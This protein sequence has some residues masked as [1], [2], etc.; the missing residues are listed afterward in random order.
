VGATAFI[1]SRGPGTEHLGGDQRHEPWASQQV[2][3]PQ[4]ARLL[5]HS[6]QPLKT[7]ALD[8]QRRP[9]NLPAD[10]TKADAH[11]D[12]YRHLTTVLL[13]G[14]PQFLF[15][16]SQSDEQDVGSGL[17]DSANGLLV[18]LR[19]LFKAH[20][21]A[22]RANDPKVREALGQDRAS[23]F[24][25]AGSATEEED[26]VPCRSSMLAEPDEQIRAGDS[27][28]EAG[29]AED[30]V[31][32][33]RSPHQRQPIGQDKV[34]GSHDLGKSRIPRHAHEMIDVGCDHHG[35]CT[36]QDEPVHRCDR[37]GHGHIVDPSIAD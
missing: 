35:R 30:Q 23:T 17:T 28:L 37:L 19:V 29:L 32:Q 2:A 31:E 14:D 15:G 11:T 36:P 25:G 10:K 5:H 12:Q 4:P 27:L 13:P 33:A 20:G 22:M 21:R 3:S 34:G 7:C 16:R 1:A 26:P 18:R 9:F 6:V 24:G 8:P